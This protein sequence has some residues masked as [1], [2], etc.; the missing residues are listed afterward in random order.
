MLAHL[1]QMSSKLPS[2]GDVDVHGEGDEGK[3]KWWGIPYYWLLLHFCPCTARTHS[4][5]MINNQCNPP[6]YYY[7]YQ[8]QLGLGGGL[9]EK[10]A[11]G[12]L[13]CGQIIKACLM[14]TEL[15]SPFSILILW[16]PIEIQPTVGVWTQH[17]HYNDDE[18]F[19]NDDYYDDDPKHHIII[20][21]QSTNL[22]PRSLMLSR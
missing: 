4:P 11:G 20:I 18:S 5:N 16:I 19:W 1:H 14:M 3:K 12:V 21:N 17:Y 6:P 13:L 9:V 22:W 2:W 7:S 15:M 10:G 8:Y